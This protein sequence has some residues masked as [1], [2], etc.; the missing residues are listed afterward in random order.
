MNWHS[1][2]CETRTKIGEHFLNEIYRFVRDV[3]GSIEYNLCDKINI[4]YLLKIHTKVLMN[5]VFVNL[6]SAGGETGTE[7][8]EHFLNEIC[9]FVRGVLGGI[10]HNLCENKD[11]INIHNY[12][13]SLYEW[14]NAL[15]FNVNDPITH[16]QILLQKIHLSLI[17]GCAAKRLSDRL[18]NYHIFALKPHASFRFFFLRKCPTCSIY[19]LPESPDPRDYQFTDGHMSKEK[20]I[21]LNLKEH[22]PA[23]SSLDQ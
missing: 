6:D 23:I 19:K 15:V 4:F 8:G 7:V 21:N 22:I 9:R 20:D 10:E 18:Q 14:A 16:V 1:A 17:G 5:R 13:Q 12:E 3:L 11:I 2:R